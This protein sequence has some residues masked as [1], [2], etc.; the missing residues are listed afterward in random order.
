MNELL[1]GK[2]LAMRAEDVRVREE[3]AAT[4]ELF[5]GYH[6]AMERVH[7]KNAAELERLV[8]EHGG[9]LG[10]SLVGADGADAAWLIVQHTI[11]LPE[12]SR[13]CLK[14]IEKSA[15]ENEAEPYQAAYLRDRISFFENRPQRYGTQSDWNADGVME[16]WTLEDRG[17]VNDYRAAVGLEPLASLTWE[18]EETRE[19]KPKNHARRQSEFEAW[20]KRVGWRK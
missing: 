20:A 13:R 7:L 12:F 18:N 15:A 2:L 17:K 19:N 4:G 9:W 1:R 3:L 10:K 11:S 16:V 5:D 8:D 14:L 6:P